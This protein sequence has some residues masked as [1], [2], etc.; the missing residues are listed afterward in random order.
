[1]LCECCASSERTICCFQLHVWLVFFVKYALYVNF[2]C[3]ALCN[4]QMHCVESSISN[5]AN[6]LMCGTRIAFVI[7]SIR[8]AVQKTESRRQKSRQM[9]MRQRAGVGSAVT[10]AA[11]S[12][13]D[14]HSPRA[15][16][17]LLSFTPLVLASRPRRPLAAS[18]RRPLRCPPSP[19]TP[20]GAAASAPPPPARRRI[21]RAR[22]T[23]RRKR[24]LRQPPHL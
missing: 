14:P 8:C 5:Y 20:R 1:M 19:R 18:L 12:R 11:T 9:W 13:I 6:D 3:L 21:P 23:R 7:V 4:T 10:A 15:R 17:C 16:R 2:C 22:R 24:R